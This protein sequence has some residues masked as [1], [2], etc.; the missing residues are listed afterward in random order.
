M[1]QDGVGGYTGARALELLRTVR[2]LRRPPAGPARAARTGRAGRR[3]PAPRSSGCPAASSSGC[4]WRWPW[5][6]VRNCCSWTSRPPAWTRRPADDLGA[7]PPAAPRRRVGRA[8]HPLPGR[9]RGA[10]RSRRGAHAGRVVAEGS[11]AELTRQGSAGTVRFSARPGLAIARPAALPAGRRGRDRAATRAIP[12]AGRGHPA[13]AGRDHHVVRGRIRAGRRADGRAAQPRGRLPVADR[14][15]TGPA[16]WP[17]PVSRCADERGSHC[18]FARSRPPRRP[19]GC[20]PPRPGW[21]CGCCCAT[22]SR[23]G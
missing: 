20:W 2:R 12:G 21:N 8:H 13:A 14:R 23:S 16:G 9:G 18:R 7:D 10:G 6:G 1:L 3:R 11:P 4:R 15:T 22:A 17:R 5:S 19:H